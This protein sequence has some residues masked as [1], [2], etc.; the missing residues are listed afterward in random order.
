MTKKWKERLILPAFLLIL[1]VFGLLAV[2]QHR[3][4]APEAQPTAE[5][6]PLPRREVVLY[7]IAADGRQLSAERRDLPGCADERLCLTET[8]TALLQG[9]RTAELLPLF[10]P[11]AALRSVAVEGATAQIDLSRAAQQE[12]PGGSR[13]ELL[14]L[15][16][17][18]NTVVANAPGLRD[19][20]LLIEGQAVQTLKGH[21]DLRQPLPAD[22]SRVRGDL[23]P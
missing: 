14:S 7:F 6:A 23:R 18:A 13:S 16:G 19:V 4:Q 9:P 17:L 11:Q 22:F 5:P 21:L 12:H 10:S 2:L 15:V 8:V 1:L 3:Q 20:R